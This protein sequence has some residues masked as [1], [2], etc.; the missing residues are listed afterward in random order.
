MSEPAHRPNDGRSSKDSRQRIWVSLIVGAALITHLGVI[1]SVAQQPLGIHD[2][3]VERRNVV[4]SLHR[5]MTVTDG[6]AGDFF[7]IYAAGEPDTPPPYG[8]SYRYLPIVGQTLGRLAATM[9]PQ[10][11]W[12]S[13]I[14]VLECLLVG[15]VVSWWRRVSDWRLRSFGPVLLLLSSPYWLEVHMGQFTFATVAVLVLGLQATEIPPRAGSLPPRRWRTK[16]AAGT[17]GVAALLKVFPLVVLPAWIRQRSSATSAAL[18]I[19]V[20]VLLSVPAFLLDPQSWTTF[21]EA[22]FSAPTG[23]MN[24]GN[25]GVVYLLHELAFEFG[26]DW[27]AASWS[28][29]S[30]GFR[31]AVLLLS[32]TLA[33]LSRRR[34][35]LAGSTLMLLAHFVSYFHVWE[36]HMSGV[37]VLGLVLLLTL[38]QSPEEHSS[39]QPYRPRPAIIGGVILALIL[40]AL[41]TP[42]A[43]LDKAHDWDFSRRVALVSSKALPTLAL[44]LIAFAA[45]LSPKASTG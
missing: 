9:P 19:S 44:Y 39:A 24:T 12:W 21:Y 4:W 8:Y 20:V 3:P 17:L 14:L 37:V 41:P 33:L 16:L 1:F 34:S 25:F 28:G 42:F 13:W 43:A 5:D 36:H 38:I 27:I 18:A 15:L 29:F 35:L 31:A 22:N 32:A 45:L 2:G 11:A 7:A 40:L 30:T 10:A 23:G 26:P 6:P